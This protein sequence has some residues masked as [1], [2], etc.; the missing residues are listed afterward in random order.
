MKLEKIRINGFGKISEKN[1]GFGKNLNIIYGSNESG[2]STIQTFIKAM[3]F[4]LGK[5]RIV[6][7]PE[8]ERYKPWNSKVYGGS[9]EYTLDNL[10]RFSV[11]RDFTS[12]QTKLYDSECKDITDE[13]DK[14]KTGGILFAQEH[15]GVNAA[16][17]ESTCFV[18][19]LGIRLDSDG[20]ALIT[21]RITNMIE[22]GSENI[23]YIKAVKIIEKA[24]V[25]EV[26]TDR[27]SER[28]INR[29]I[30]SI[31]H[32]EKERANCAKVLQNIRTLEEERKELKKDEMIL[33][34]ETAGADA[35]YKAKKV[36]RQYNSIQMSDRRVEELKINLEQ[37]ETELK[38]IA[39]N[40]PLGSAVFDDDVA[41]QLSDLKLLIR[42]LGFKFKN[43]LGCGMGILIYV[44]GSVVVMKEVLLV[45]MI[46][47]A[48]SVMTILIGFGLYYRPLV[49]AKSEIGEILTAGSVNSASEYFD[50]KKEIMF[51]LEKKRII[52]E[53]A[54]LLRNQ[55]ESISRE[56]E[57]ETAIDLCNTDMNMKEIQNELLGE[58]KD[59]NSY[60]LEQ[61]SK[62]K[63]YQL[64]E[65]ELRIIEIET[66]IKVLSSQVIK[67]P[68]IEEQL[69]RDRQE[70]K[71]LE[72][73]AWCLV[74]AKE[75]LDES[76]HQ[77]KSNIIPGL[78][79]KLSNIA[80]DL[81]GKYSNIKADVGG[82]GIKIILE[83]GNVISP[84][85]LSGGTIDQIY[86][87]LRVA[88]LDML[89]ENG[90]LLPLILDEPFSQFDDNRIKI[91]AGILNSIS[92]KNQV[93]IFT[94]RQNEVDIIKNEIPNAQIIKI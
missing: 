69:E 75:I 55:L 93:I 31:K 11:W 83:D 4:G 37:R 50:K 30:E 45:N 46:L 32:L 90:E 39:D 60:E 62:E 76:N 38:V 78:S 57:T 12:N 23:S 67:L 63:K 80:Y 51:L 33:I 91:T 73:F 92:K 56:N 36:E 64:H 24:L 77:L 22:A 48:I 58:L 13:Y 16:L 21:D 7:I 47:S 27:T 42:K 79:N 65:T 40:I 44:L 19:Q 74:K 89:S 85:L 49:K 35:L 10:R 3:L 71:K 1:I 66:E 28:P 68:E 25:E 53:S 43:L 72:E 18:S 34:Q 6:G 9:L 82:Q 26:G 17:F 59:M 88:G 87:A 15:L 20:E 2:K 61:Y 94:C 54:A 41:N 29:V 8:K 70:K 84:D 14:S 81:T 5:N 52:E 86:F